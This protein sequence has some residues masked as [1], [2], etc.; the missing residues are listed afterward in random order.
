MTPDGERLAPVTS[1]FGRRPAGG[2]VDDGAGVR[3]IDD[4]GNQSEWST[5]ADAAAG[6]DETV[7]VGEA[8]G[9]AFRETRG[10]RGAHPA[11]KG[12]ATL[13]AA[14][15]TRK[16]VALPT[17][18]AFAARSEPSAAGGHM[19]AAER[20]ADEESDDQSKVETV[21]AARDRAE[22]I[23]MHALTRRGVSSL[24]MA[25]TLRSRDLPEEVVLD[26]VERLER[27]G[28]L[29]DG[30]LAEN[31]VHSKQERKGLGKGA[32]NAELRQRGLAQEAIDAALADIDD[33]DEQT[34]ADSWALKRAGQLRGL[35]Q[36]TAER[37]LTAFLLRR[38]YRSEVV[39]RAL[40][41]ALP[42]GGGSGH[43]R[44]E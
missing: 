23:S 29:D 3:P 10:G 9:V 11:G 21:E 5:A 22:K 28:L 14:D 43:V 34:R 2:Q 20:E 36:A 12:Q 35:D 7:G 25:K 32:I 19:R 13:Q 42:R 26:E 24:E 18:A 31:L 44:F 27:V 37:R 30:A 33:D 41:K 40:E 15:S 16:L 8:A 6:A 4:G 39:R 17:Y 38:G 1:L